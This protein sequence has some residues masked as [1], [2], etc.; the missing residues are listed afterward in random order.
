M[1]LAWLM[2]VIAM[3]IVYVLGGLIILF[4]CCWLFYKTIVYAK[5]GDSLRASY[6]VAFL[7]L[8]IAAMFSK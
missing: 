1:E 2:L 7:A 4:S 3:L 8:I 6:C 5:Q